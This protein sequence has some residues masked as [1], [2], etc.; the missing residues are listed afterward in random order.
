M[1]KSLEELLKRVSKL[2][3]DSLSLF[4]YKFSTYISE[5]AIDCSFQEKYP[6][7]VYLIEAKDNLEMAALYFKKAHNTIIRK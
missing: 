6:T 7:A 5:Q 2:P 1:D 4:T 3:Y